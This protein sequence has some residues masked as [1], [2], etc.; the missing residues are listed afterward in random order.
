MDGLWND[1]KFALRTLVRAPTFTLVAVGTLAVGIGA[2]TAIFS[3]VDS[4]LL[5]ALPYD[6]AENLVTAWLDL[7]ERDGLAKEWFAS[8]DLA[9]FRAEPGLFEEIGGWRGWGPTL[10]ELGDPTVLTA[11]RITQ[12]TFEGVLRVQPFL[13][14]GFLPEE[15]M[16]QAAGTVILSHAF[17][18]ERFGGDRSA[19]GR[20]IILNEEPYSVIGVM[21]EGFVPPFIPDAELWTAAR[22]DPADCGRGCYSVR[23]VARLAPG[24]TI[25]VARQRVQRVL[26][27]CRI[28]EL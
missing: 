1:T 7:S 20:P 10:T 17:W 6:E 2:N 27:I 15:D 28:V 13:G 8:E 5:R 3:V 23:T 19:L 24:V 26:H 12:R 4:V 11:A 18:Q 21:P 22:L 14:R 25:E 16:P 9:D